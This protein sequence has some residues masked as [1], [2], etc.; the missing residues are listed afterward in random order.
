MGC[1]ECGLKFILSDSYESLEDDTYWNHI[2]RKIYSVP[3]V[4]NEFEKKHKKYL[5]YIIKNCSRNKKILDVGSGSGIFLNNAKKYNFEISGIEPSEIAVELCKE[6][7]NI[8]VYC[9]YLELNSELQKDYGVLSAWD[10]IEHVADPKEF[11][12]ICH[13]HLIEGGTLLLETPDESCVIR[14]MIN[15]IDKIRRAFGFNSSSNIYY[16]AHLYYFTHKSITHLLNDVGFTNIKIFRE[17]SIFSKSKEKYRLYN[18]LTRIQIFKYDIL[19]FILKFPLFWNKQVI[20][21][22]KE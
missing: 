17:H 13:A 22:T 12:K 3:G 16:P 11:L 6:L 1:N 2:N 15:L 21:C 8:K 19:F 18:N 14:K 20:L 5:D 9:G 4:L 7:Y 10:V